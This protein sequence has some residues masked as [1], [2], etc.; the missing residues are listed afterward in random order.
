MRGSCV[1]DEPRQLAR[2]RRS[3][4]VTSSSASFSRLL[5]STISSGST[6]TVCPDCDV[7]CTMPRTCERASTRIGTT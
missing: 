2:M 7:P 5:R 4:S 3:S 6:N 1:L